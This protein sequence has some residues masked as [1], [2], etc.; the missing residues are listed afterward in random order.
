MDLYHDMCREN[1]IPDA[2]SL[3]S[4]SLPVHH[5][6]RQSQL[7]HATF[8]LLPE[9]PPQ[10]LHDWQTS[11]CRHCAQ[12][13]TCESNDIASTIVAMLLITHM[14]QVTYHFTTP[15]EST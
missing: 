11:T 3:P 9:L 10:V 15:Q 2:S 1:K 8:V 5:H 7:V 6:Q 12:K 14:Q 4:S 13:L